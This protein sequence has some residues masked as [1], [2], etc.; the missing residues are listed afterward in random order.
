[1]CLCG[2]IIGVIG[3][4]FS[5]NAPDKEQ[6]I[7]M[8]LHFDHPLQQKTR[9]F[10]FDEDNLDKSKEFFENG[11]GESRLSASGLP[12]GHLAPVYFKL[13][14]DDLDLDEMPPEAFGMAQEA[15]GGFRSALY[16]NEEAL[17]GLLHK[18]FNKILGKPPSRGPQWESAS[19]NEP[20]KL[21][22]YDPSEK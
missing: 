16:G 5:P 19:R 14:V 1:M 2:N 11:S 15:N 18:V 21:L 13:G 4:D 22:G 20:P 10:V 3:V 8:R 12:G 9:L 6:L 7:Q 17:N